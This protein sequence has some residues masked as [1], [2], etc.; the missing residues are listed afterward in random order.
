MEDNKPT[1][2]HHSKDHGVQDTA[3]FQFTMAERGIGNHGC[4]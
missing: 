2:A 1:N 3:H 4:E